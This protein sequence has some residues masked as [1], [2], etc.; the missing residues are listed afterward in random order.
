ML[1]AF[2]NLL[3]IQEKSV[4]NQIIF[5][6][7]LS[8]WSEVNWTLDMLNSKFS[9]FI[10]VLG[11]CCES[12]DLHSQCVGILDCQMTKSSNTNNSTWSTNFLVPLDW[13]ISCNTGTKKWRH[14]SN[15][16]SC[17][18]MED[19]VFIN[20]HMRSISSEVLS[21]KENSFVTKV[22]IS[23]LAV[24]L[25]II[26]WISDGTDTNS[27]SNFNKWNFW[28]YFGDLSNNLMSWTAG[29]PAFSPMFSDSCQIR[30][31]NWG[32]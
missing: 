18:N 32:V 15:V 29:I 30:M 11:L 31:A 2:I 1:E 17:G 12:C 7:I 4:D 25:T 27:I 22:G 21:V 5:S 28:T 6:F 8:E 16:H 20:L 26:A 10:K 13:G 24:F 3:I 19:P 14:F 9:Q 23:F